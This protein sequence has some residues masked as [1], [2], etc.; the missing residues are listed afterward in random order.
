MIGAA[1][2]PTRNLLTGLVSQL[3]QPSGFGLAAF[4]GFVL[5]LTAA[6]V[7][8]LLWLELAVRSAAVGAA[9]LFLPL[10]L[11]GL[12]WP[13]T[14]H[15]A[16]RLGETLAALVLSKLVIA[17]VL[18]LAAGL[19]VSSSGGASVVEGVALLAIAAFSP[20]SL[21]KLV[22]AVEAGAIGHFE[23]LSRRPIRAAHL[24]LVGGD[25]AAF[26]A[27]L[28]GAARG[29]L[30]SG[31]SSRPGGSSPD[32]GRWG[33]DRQPPAGS[34]SGVIPPLDRDTAGISGGPG[35]S[36]AQDGPA[37]RPVAD[38]SDEQ[39]AARP[40]G[41]A[42]PWGAGPVI[43]V[44]S[45]PPRSPA[46]TGGVPAADVSPAAGGAVPVVHR[47]PGDAVS[48]TAAPPEDGGKDVGPHLVLSTGEQDHG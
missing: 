12:A 8:F 38:G 30:G 43:T 39:S 11:I 17:A 45:S 6:I 23:G 7:A 44:T 14:A 4:G 47:A 2:D 26:L 5:V 19:L 27:N 13:A 35:P 16:R 48:R 28:G 40:S 29:G 1:G 10:A 36:D 34:A 21:L 9:A 24:A 46:D 3:V 42:G 32:P 41:A 20:F 22:P 37:G 15:W 33:P 25:G 18:A 31:G